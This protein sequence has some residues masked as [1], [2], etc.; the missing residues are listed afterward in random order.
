MTWQS[1]SGWTGNLCESA[2]ELSCGLLLPA[3]PAWCLQAAFDTGASNFHE[4]GSFCH[5]DHIALA[6]FSSSVCDGSANKHAAL[7]F[8]DGNE[9]IG[10]FHGYSEGCHGS[11]QGHD[12]P[13]IRSP[14]QDS[15]AARESRDSD[16][17]DSTIAASS[18]VS[19]RADWKEG[20]F[21][22]SRTKAPIL[23]IPC[24]IPTGR[25]DIL[26]GKIKLVKSNVM[27]H[28]LSSAPLPSQP[29]LVNPGTDTIARATSK[30]FC[31]PFLFPIH[32]NIHNGE[33][34]SSPPSALITWFLCL[35]GRR[36]RRARS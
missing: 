35:N 4:S 1:S 13:T 26:A 22:A 5:Y 33:I 9:R 25:P 21:P 3:P 31:T 17:S 30:R 19:V 16:S 8:S 7:Q 23:T 28:K 15:R 32:P 2:T 12:Q 6:D 10:A 27:N 29:E 11:L 36:S 34:P 20:I 14:I 24:G 18:I